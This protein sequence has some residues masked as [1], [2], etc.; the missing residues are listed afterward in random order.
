MG[1][2]TGVNSPL[3][4]GLVAIAVLLAVVVLAASIYY[5]VGPVEN[6]PQ[7]AGT[8]P[9]LQAVPTPTLRAEQPSVAETFVPRQEATPAPREDNVNLAP[10]PAFQVDPDIWLDVAT[11]SKYSDP[12]HVPSTVTG[13]TPVPKALSV[14]PIVIHASTAPPTPV[15]PAVADEPISNVPTVEVGQVVLSTA[16][17]LQASDPAPQIPGGGRDAQVQF[18]PKKPDL[19]YPN[20]GSHL[21]QLVASVEEGQVTAREAARGAPIHQ[22]DSVA[23]T[24]HLSAKADAVVRFLEEKGA[25][26]RNVGVDYIEAY[27]PVTLLGPLSH[28]PGV[29]R[30]REIVPPQP[31]GPSGGPAPP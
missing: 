5:I 27:V 26:P 18:K 28:Q 8:S 2:V 31:A 6:S 20:L 16:G 11:Q 1:K 17:K 22:D 13:S 19:K 14:D 25:D 7:L 12:T 9:Q 30:V 3:R 10:S 29:T 23:V 21:N 15:E 4:L 24:I